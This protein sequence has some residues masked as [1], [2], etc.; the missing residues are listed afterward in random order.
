V[1]GT[2]QAEGKD[3][4]LQTISGRWLNPE[5]WALAEKKLAVKKFLFVLTKIPLD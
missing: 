3:R 4:G 1:E 5:R 2:E